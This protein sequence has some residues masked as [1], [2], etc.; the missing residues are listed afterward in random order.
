MRFA[1]AEAVKPLLTDGGEVAFLDVREHGQYGEGHPFFSVNL[2][3]S[4]L[5]TL[6]PAL[7]PR[8]SV[9]CVLFD[10]GDGVAEKSVRRLAALGYDDLTVMTG[11]APAWAAAGLSLSASIS[12]IATPPLALRIC[13]LVRSTSRWS[14]RISARS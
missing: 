13:A 3:Y 12:M 14:E 7:L 11:G 2:P 8:R 4:R 9:R 10:D 6:A 5:E 1:D